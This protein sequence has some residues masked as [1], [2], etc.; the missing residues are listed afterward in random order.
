MILYL[1]DFLPPFFLV[2]YQYN[3]LQNHHRLGLLFDPDYRVVI[4]SGAVLLV[5][6][7]PPVREVHR[8]LLLNA[9]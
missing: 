5:E 9:I 2:A 8:H 6:A 4:H 7:D 3:Q 1:P